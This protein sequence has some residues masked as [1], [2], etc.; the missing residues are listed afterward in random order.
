MRPRIFKRAKSLFFVLFIFLFADRQKKPFYP[1][2]FTA[3]PDILTFF[4]KRLLRK[5]AANFRDFQSIG[6]G[7]IQ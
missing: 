5:D 7:H 3:P 1:C 4:R 6:G 2:F